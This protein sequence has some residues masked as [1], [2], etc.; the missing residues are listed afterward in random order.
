MSELLKLHVPASPDPNIGLLLKNCVHQAVNISEADFIIHPILLREEMKIPKTIAGISRQHLACK[1]K[2]IPF[3]LSDYEGKYAFHENLVLLR[4][5]VL[6]DKLAANE[7]VLPYLWECSDEAFAP[8]PA[9]D[10]PSIGFCG[11]ISKAR[12]KLVSAF[13]GTGA[14]HCNF[15]K[16]NSFWGGKPH[17][18]GLKK[19]FWHNL[20]ENQF[21]LAPRGAGNFSM[22]FYQALSV[23]RIPVLVDTNVALPFD[24][25]IPWPELIV[26]EKNENDCIARVREIHAGGET[27]ARQEKCYRTF[28]EFLSPR[29]FMNRLLPR[30]KQGG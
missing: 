12:K 20:R 13:E 2:V 28:H 19:D 23:G 18:A 27:F 10:L 6:A 8:A 5:S 17:D 21:A 9:A 24:D 4:T 1:K 22:R 11:L 29:V 3:I 14:I 7:R 30:L 26:F 16:R 25:L 15:I